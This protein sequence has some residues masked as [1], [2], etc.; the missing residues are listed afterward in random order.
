MCQCRV[1]KRLSHTLYVCGTLIKMCQYRVTKR[2]SHTLY[3]FRT[4]IKM[5][6]YR[7]TWFSYRSHLFF[8]DIFKA[9]LNVRKLISAMHRSRHA[10][11]EIDSRMSP[12]NNA[13]IV[14]TINKQYLFMRMLKLYSDNTN[15][16][17]YIF[18]YTFASCV[19]TKRFVF[20]PNFVFFIFI[21]LLLYCFPQKFITSNILLLTDVNY[22]RRDRSIKI[23]F[24]P[25]FS[26]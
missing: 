3:D 4:P 2:L 15:K 25:H 20:L 6:Q 1:T 24:F 21:L 13:P 19:Y 23:D 17:N 18:C 9:V 7:V 22:K 5:C 10:V 14:I 16:L 26:N 11:L 12:S 8:K